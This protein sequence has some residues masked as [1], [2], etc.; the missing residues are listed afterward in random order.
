MQTK[1]YVAATLLNVC[2]CYE[3]NIK[4][5]CSKKYHNKIPFD[6]F[7]KSEI[8]SHLLCYLQKEV[9]IYDFL[10]SYNLLLFTTIIYSNQNLL[11]KL[12]IFFTD[13]VIETK[14]V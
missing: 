6:I 9:K 10:K 11:K 4:I 3:Y 1:V 7:I 5:N 12:K 8:Y 13:N 2:E 14:Y